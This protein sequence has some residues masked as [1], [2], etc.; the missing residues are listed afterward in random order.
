VPDFLPHPSEQA[1]RAALQVK[2]SDVA[3]LEARERAKKAAG[4][5]KL[6]D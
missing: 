6:G 4:K 3:K 5:K 2:P 1:L